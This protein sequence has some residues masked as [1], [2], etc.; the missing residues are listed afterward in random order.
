[1]H[2]ERAETG[3]L[4][5]AG[6]LDVAVDA[7]LAQDRHARPRPGVDERGGDVIGWIEG[8]ARL[9]PRRGEVARDRPLLVGAVGVVA[10]L[11]H[12][13]GDR[14]PGVEQL[15]PAPLGQQR[16]LAPHA[17]PGHRGGAGDALGVLGQR[18]ALDQVGEGGAILVG[19]LHHRAQL[20]VEQGAE[21]VVAPGIQGDVQAAARCE[22]HLAQRGERT[23]VAAV[24]VGEQQ[25]GLARVA[26]ELEEAAQAGRMVQVRHVAAERRQGLAAGVH[27]GQHRTAEALL[28]T[29]QADQPQLA[30]VA[31]G[32]ERGQLPA[33]V[34]HR[35]ERRHDQRDR[36][37]R[38]VRLA[39]GVPLRLHRQ[40]V[41]ADRD[42]DVQVRAQLHADRAHR[43]VQQRV[44]A[45]MPAGR[46]PV[47]R[48]LDRVER[49]H[50]RGAQVGDRLAHRHARGGRRIEQRQRG[51]L[52]DAHGLAGD[53][54]EIGQ[55]DCAVRQGKLPGTDHLV[56]RG[57]AADAAVADGDQ[58]VLR[59]HG[60]M[61]EHAQP[62]PVQVQRRGGQRRPGRGARVRRVAVHLRRLAEQHVHR[63]VDGVSGGASGP[64]VRAFANARRLRLRAGHRCFRLRGTAARRIRTPGALRRAGGLSRDTVDALDSRAI[65]HDQPLL[66][67]GHADGGERATL[68]RADRGEL[69]EPVGRHAEH[70]ALLGFVAPQFQRRQ[71]RVVGRHLGQVDDPAHA[72]I[73]QQFG[74]GV[75]QAT[76]AD[77]M[78]EVDRVALA[79][80]HAAVDDLLA[81]ALHLRVVALDAGEVQVLGTLAGG[82]RTGR[83]AAEADQ[84]RR[85][86]QHDHRVAR[87]QA[88]LVDLDA[89]D[90]AQ[91]AGQHDRLVVGAAEGASIGRVALRQLEAAEV[92]Q[93]VRPAEFVVER[94][95]AQRAV[96]H[97]LQRRRHARVERAW[98][99]PRLRQ[100][101][102]AQVRH[103]ET[104]QAGLGLAAAA[105]R[106]LVADLAAGTGGSTRE[107][108]DRGRVV[109]GL[110]LDL[111]R[112]GNRGFGAVLAGRRIR[113]VARGE[114]SLDHRGV[115]AV[116]A[117]GML[118]RLLVGVL[119]HPEQGA[120]LLLPV[121]GP[122][123]VEDLVPAV[124]GIGLREHHQLDVRRVAPQLRIARAQVVDLVVGQGQAQAAVG[125]FQVGERD[126]LQRLARRAGEQRLRRVARLQQRL[127]HRVVQQLAH[128]RLRRRVGRPA[129]DVQPQ[130]AL[131][132]R[133]RQSGALQQLGGLARPGRTRAQAG[134]HEVRA[135][136]PGQ[137]GLAVAGL[138]DAVQRG[139]IGRGVAGLD[140][141]DVPGAFDAKAGDQGL[142]AGLEPLPAER[143]KGGRALEDDHV[144]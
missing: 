76:G 16:A 104:G 91:A 59:C 5:R 45:R 15:L 46:H 74:N 88:D 105:G 136:A 101:G 128:R 9:E 21:R 82:H 114:V 103:R 26:D 51:T 134:D 63:Q 89:V 116:R 112:R 108:R 18:V 29:A 6:H 4:E 94:G 27:L 37:H 77:V 19:H 78:E 48:Q 13:V 1:M 7:L 90:R 120:L 62:G 122:A 69:L 124:L 28:A 20:F 55:R 72:G 65:P 106:A 87:L 10:Q 125:A 126:A 23:T 110:D 102:D 49:L 132:P 39:I 139:R 3:A 135:R 131:D 30:V 44:F 137:R 52:A 83:A 100:G 61:R 115:V 64:L 141:V 140:E 75:G 107:R 130:A 133:H 96:E 53:A 111:E 129:G 12:G 34:H 40:R 121:D 119:D 22:R 68:A 54:V 31:I 17:H 11:L 143:R 25:A 33:H 41:L 144:R 14:P 56:A 66:G 8:Q 85:P 95:A 57:Q 71:R 86:A 84:H 73:V 99:L 70:V 81:A 117:Q 92:A 42:R 36:R 138:E 127:G 32:Q 79:H 97:D 24:V 98:R 113:A 47:G 93:Q 109:V 35:G 123:G 80:R 50:R 43:V 58:E 2:V 142:Q 38:L 118:R 67:G 60:R